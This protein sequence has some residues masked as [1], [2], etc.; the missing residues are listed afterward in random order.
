MCRPLSASA[1]L[2]YTLKS[3]C[4][5]DGSVSNVFAMQTRG[6]D[7]K[8]LNRCKSQVW[9]KVPLISVEAETGECPENNVQIRVAC[10]LVHLTKL[11]I[12]RPER[13]PVS[14]KEEIE[15]DT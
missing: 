2:R 11:I 14:N 10:L 12:S 9:W 15:E 6:L 4:W 3:L 8:A 13:G 5:E 7:F 1:A